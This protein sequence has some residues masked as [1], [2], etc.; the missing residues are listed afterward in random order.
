MKL[1]S[2]LSFYLPLKSAVLARNMLLPYCESAVCS[3]VGS[4]RVDKISTVEIGY[5]FVEVTGIMPRTYSI[6][7]VHPKVLNVVS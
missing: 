3:Y 6:Q 7:R 5:I 4:T 1:Q 2:C